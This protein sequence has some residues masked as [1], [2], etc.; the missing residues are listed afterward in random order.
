MNLLEM[1]KPLRNYWKNE[2]ERRKTRKRR[3]MARKLSNPKNNNI[4]TNLPSRHGINLGNNNRYSMRSNNRG[5]TPL[6]LN[7]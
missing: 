2:N 7:E 6:K 5:R 1:D 3:R 4:M